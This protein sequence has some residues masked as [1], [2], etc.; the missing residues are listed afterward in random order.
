M[1]GFRRAF[2]FLVAAGTGMTSEFRFDLP[3]WRMTMTQ[4]E[5]LL[6]RC[7]IGNLHFQTIGCKGSK[8]IVRGVTSHMFMILTCYDE[9]EVL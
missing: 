5:S 8:Q 3:V 9:A 7:H 2:P 1:S 6:L 4:H